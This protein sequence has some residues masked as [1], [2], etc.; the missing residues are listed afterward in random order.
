MVRVRQCSSLSSPL[1]SDGTG[2]WFPTVSMPMAKGM[3]IAAMARIGICVAAPA[4]RSSDAHRRRGPTT[5]HRNPDR[6]NPDRT[7]RAEFAEHLTDARHG[8]DRWR[9]IGNHRYGPQFADSLQRG[10]CRAHHSREQEPPEDDGHRKAADCRR[11]SHAVGRRI[12]WHCGGTLLRHPAGATGSRSID[13][14]LAE[15]LSRTA[16]PSTMPL[17]GHEVAAAR[18]DNRA[19][20]A[21]CQAS[22]DSVLFNPGQRLIPARP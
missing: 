16:V 5:L 17:G 21:R 8:H 18:P 2:T 19:S 11:K 9:F 1:L 3:P 14:S 15:P 7:V 10:H 22:P 12:D 4:S 6:H 13:L 20:L